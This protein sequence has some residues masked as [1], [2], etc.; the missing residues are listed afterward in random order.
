[1]D[2]RFA[3]AAGVL[4]VAGAGCGARHATSPSL[5]CLHTNGWVSA[6]VQ[7]SNVVILE[8]DDGHAAVRLVF[9]KNEAAA[10]RA[11]PGLAPIGVGWR[12][13]V[14]WRSSAGFT[15][16]DEQTLDR[17]LGPRR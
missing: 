10:R 6:A 11:I 16:A 5:D 12:G 9:W 15:L 3:V 2:A 1:M 13:K 17:C 8:A 4:L 7:H 14:S